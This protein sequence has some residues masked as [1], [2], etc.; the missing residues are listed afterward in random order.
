[1][2][3]CLSLFLSCLIQSQNTS[4]VPE[5]EQS[6]SESPSQTA[7]TAESPEQPRSWRPVHAAKYVFKQVQ[8]NQPTHLNYLHASS[9]KHC[10]CNFSLVQPS[11]PD[12][13]DPAPNF[14][15]AMDLAPKRLNAD[16]SDPCPLQ[17]IINSVFTP[18]TTN[19]ALSEQT[20]L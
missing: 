15:Q 9:C 1:M 20:G 3:P 11:R 17:P 18:N 14:L 8:C 12:T 5:E 13:L 4:R 16:S 2:K 19:S 7:F 6:S 10:K